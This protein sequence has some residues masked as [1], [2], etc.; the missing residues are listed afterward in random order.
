LGLVEEVRRLLA[1]PKPLSREARQALGYRE[2]M[3]HLDGKQGLEATIMAVKTHSRQFAK[4]QLTWFRRLPGCFPAS[5]ELTG[6][7]WHSTMKG[8]AVEQAAS[9]ASLP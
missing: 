3:E 8:S 9:A 4:R 7:L 2:V 6:Q 1:L 5:T